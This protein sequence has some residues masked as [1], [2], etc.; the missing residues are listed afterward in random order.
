MFTVR[1]QG[2]QAVFL[3]SDDILGTECPHCG[4]TRKLDF[5]LPYGVKARRNEIEIRELLEKLGDDE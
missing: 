2:C 1:C 4:G 3:S 5:D